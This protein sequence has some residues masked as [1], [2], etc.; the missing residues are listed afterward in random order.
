MI[1]SMHGT[2]ITAGV[3]DL[4]ESQL[5]LPTTLFTMQGTSI[6]SNGDVVYFL[7]RDIWKIQ[8][9]SSIYKY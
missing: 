7:A 4:S 6:I 5:L 2:T 3:A 1:C 9:V 8:D